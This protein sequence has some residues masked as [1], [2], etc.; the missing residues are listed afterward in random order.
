MNSFFRK[1]NWLTKRSCKEAELREELQFHLE[2]EAKQRREGGSP[3]DEAKWFARRELGNLALV[4]EST[5]ASWG[6]TW[7]PAS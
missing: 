5:R 2:A 3:S 1:L 6:W 7:T 4:A